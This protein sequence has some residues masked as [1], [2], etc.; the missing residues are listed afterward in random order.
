MSVEIRMPELV[1]KQQKDKFSY[2]GIFDRSSKKVEEPAP[3]VSGTVE[4]KVVRKKQAEEIPVGR[5]QLK[6]GKIKS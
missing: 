2:P 1:D 3:I 5:K 6:L 4:K